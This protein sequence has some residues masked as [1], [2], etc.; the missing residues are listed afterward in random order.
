MI[1]A[2]WTRRPGKN[3]AANSLPGAIGQ[4]LS[5]LERHT[6]RRRLNKL[7]IGERKNHYTANLLLDHL[8][9]SLLSAVVKFQAEL[10]SCRMSEMRRDGEATGSEPARRLVGKDSDDHALGDDFNLLNAF[11]TGERWLAG[12]QSTQHRQAT[13]DP[14]RIGYP[15]LATT[16]DQ[17][18]DHPAF[19]ET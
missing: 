6:G 16:H 14:I 1:W 19:G 10:F 13:P 2:A 4:R 5:E 7:V 18:T 15:A 17:R 8:T 3:R 12:W 9:V 11:S